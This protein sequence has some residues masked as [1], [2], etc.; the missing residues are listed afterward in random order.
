MR[1]EKLGIPLI[2]FVAIAIIIFIFI[3]NLN[4]K[5]EITTI[6][7]QRMDIIEKVMAIGKI[8]P[9]NEIVIKS[10]FSGIVQRIFVEKGDKIF[11]GMPLI[12]VKPDPTPLEIAEAKNAVELALSAMENLKNEYLR[13]RELFNNKLISQKEFEEAE[14]NYKEANLKLNL[15]QQRLA[16]IEKGKTIISDKS[17]ESIIRSPIDGTVLEVKVNKGDPIVPLTFY[18]AGTELMILANMEE[19]IFKGTVDEID[20][21]KLEEGMDADVKIGAIPDEIIK[22]KVYKISLKAKEQE[23]AKVFEIEIKITKRGGKII[24]AGYSATAEIIVKKRE[25]VLAIPER[26]VEFKGNNA[27]V[28]IKD[29]E[30][31]ILEREVEIGLSDGLNIEVIRGLNEGEQ[32][33]ESSAIIK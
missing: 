9:K 7:V 12:E 17:T 8:V 14:R 28:K 30:G 15:A 26:L 4:P 16:L 21:G 1:I 11:T 23:T 6:R 18:Q 29:S 22:G 32:V 13:K 10:K 3:K 5:N 33:V 2:I 20:V 19:L 24:R 27:F 25:N 31:R